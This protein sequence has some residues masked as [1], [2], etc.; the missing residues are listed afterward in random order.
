MPGLS[1]VHSRVAYLL[2]RADD[3]DGAI[4]AARTALSI[5]PRNAEAYRFLGLGLYASAR[6]MAAIHAFRESLTL[7]A[8]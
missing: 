8:Q 5:D 3:A 7:S 2:Y 6:Y 1:D 4:A